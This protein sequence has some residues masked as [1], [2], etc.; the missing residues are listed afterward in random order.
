MFHEL[1]LQ[2]PLRTVNTFIKQVLEDILTD[3]STDSGRLGSMIVNI[4]NK[5]VTGSTPSP[6]PQPLPPL[7]QH[8]Y[9]VE[10]VVSGVVTAKSKADTV[11]L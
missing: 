2:G 6:S 4:Q 1:L 7:G 10:R 3:V 11:A 5:G 9:E 8:E